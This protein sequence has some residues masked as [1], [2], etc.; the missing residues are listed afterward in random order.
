MV[1]YRLYLLI[2]ILFVKFYGYLEKLRLIFMVCNVR[3]LIWIDVGRGRK[4]SDEEVRDR[5]CLI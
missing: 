3:E 2:I 4:G 5:F 1:L